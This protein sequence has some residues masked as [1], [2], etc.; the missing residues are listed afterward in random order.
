MPG[1][2]FLRNPITRDIIPTAG[3][4][5]CLIIYSQDFCLKFI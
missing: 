2:G 4:G 1:S 5:K 3:F